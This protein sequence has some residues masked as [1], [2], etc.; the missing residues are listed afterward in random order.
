MI[1]RILVVGLLFLGPIEDLDVAV[2][3][4]V[5]THRA[6]ALEPA[7]QFA[8]HAGKPATVLGLLLGVAVFG[9]PAGV[10]TARAAL[11]TAAAVNLVVE[12]LKRS[13]DRWRPDG[14]H[15]P[16]NA[17]FPSSH[18]A[19]AAALAFV[20]GRRWPRL[21]WLFGLLAAWVAVSRIWLDRHYLSDVVVG[22]AIGVAGAWGVAR[23]M[24]TRASGS[25][26]RRG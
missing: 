5:Q 19:N 15:K 18:A 20:F 21:A 16:S 7:M 25:R 4:A 12:V 24:E 13:T 10:A 17:S 26:A 22:V 3:H 9:G 23:L 8:T 1:A 11:L 14:E 2:R 6:A